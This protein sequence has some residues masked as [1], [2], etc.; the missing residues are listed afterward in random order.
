MSLVHFLSMEMY[1]TYPS[2]LV[3]NE[4]AFKDHLDFLIENT[5]AT[6]A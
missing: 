3:E 5:T 1:Q 2:L 4:D 6:H